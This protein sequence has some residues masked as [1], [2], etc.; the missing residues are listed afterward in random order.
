MSLI[1]IYSMSGYMFPA[2]KGHLQ[3]TYFGVIENKMCAAL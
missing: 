2:S 3:A 1:Y